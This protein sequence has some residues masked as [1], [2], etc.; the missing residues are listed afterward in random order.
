VTPLHHYRIAVFLLSVTLL[1]LCAGPDL[2]ARPAAAE[3]CGGLSS[4]LIAGVA[5]GLLVAVIWARRVLR[6]RRDDWLAAT[7]SW[8]PPRRP[9]LVSRRWPS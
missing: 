6:H 8:G 3:G 2:P 7:G 4:Y 9:H 1:G 5:G